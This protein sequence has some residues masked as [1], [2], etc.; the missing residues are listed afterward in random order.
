MMELL[1]LSY[2]HQC[3]M[4]GIDFKI[5]SFHDTLMNVSFILLIYLFIV[6]DNRH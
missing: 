3:V 5:D 4:K 6:S 2:I 1:P